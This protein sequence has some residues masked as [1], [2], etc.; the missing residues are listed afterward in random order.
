MNRISFRTAA[1][2]TATVAMFAMFAMSCSEPFGVK[3]GDSPPVIAVYGTLTNEPDRHSVQVTVSSSYFD[4]APNRGVSGAEVTLSFENNVLRYAEVSGSPGLYR[5]IDTVAGKPGTKYTL[6][7]RADFKG[8]KFPKTYE[9]VST[10]PELC[11]PESVQVRRIQQSGRNLYSV[12]PYFQDSP[13]KDFYLVRYKINDSTIYNQLFRY[14]ITDDK[15]FNGQ[16]VNGIMFNIFND[17]SEKGKHEENP[18]TERAYLQKGDRLTFGISKIEPGFFDFIQQCKQGR[19]GENPFFGGP[20][21]NFVTN[22]TN[23]AV[24][25]FSAHAYGRYTVV[26]R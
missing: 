1:A 21:S 9:A 12:H 23:G 16:Y 26:I 22:L 11:V 24:G 3:T 4:A 18:D 7:V 8:N 19:N 2:A 5:T 17:I 10:M 15:G 13:A 20:P 25:Y 14:T 6:R